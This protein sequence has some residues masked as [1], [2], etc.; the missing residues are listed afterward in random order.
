MT[1]V[2]CI[3]KVAYD[4][5]EGIVPTTVLDPDCILGQRPTNPIQ[6]PNGL[7]LIL[8]QSNQPVDST[9][10][11]GVHPSV[12]YVP[13]GWNGKKWWMAFTPYP[14][15][16]AHYETPHILCADDPRDPNGWKVPEGGSNPI[17]PYVAG[18]FH[19][20]PHL[21]L[22]PD[23]ILYCYYGDSATGTFVCRFST[24]GITWSEK[25][26]VINDPAAMSPAIMFD[27]GRYR[28]WYVHLIRE[29]D[30]QGPFADQLETVVVNG[31]TQKVIYDIA[32]VNDENSDNGILY[33]KIESGEGNTKN[34]LFYKD[35]DG[36]TP[37]ASA[38]CTG[39][40]KAQISQV[41]YSGISGSIQLKA[42][43]QL[44]SDLA[45]NTI[46]LRRLC[47]AES[48]HP[49]SDFSPVSRHILP[50]FADGP[51]LWHLSVDKNGSMFTGTF[52][53]TGGYGHNLHI[54]TS[55]DGTTWK[56]PEFPFLASAKSGTCGSDLTG[57]YGEGLK[58]RYLYRGQ[59][60]WTTPDTGL[61]F[62]SARD[63]FEQNLYHTWRIFVADIWIN[64]LIVDA[65]GSTPVVAALWNKGNVADVNGTGVAVDFNVGAFL[66]YYTARLTYKT[67]DA[68]YNLQ[69]PIFTLDLQKKGTAY[70]NNVT[71]VT[72]S[73]DGTGALYMTPIKTIIG[74]GT[75]S[76]VSGQYEWTMPQ[77]GAG[78]K[79]VLVWLE[80]LVNTSTETISFPEHFLK[81]PHVY[82]SSSLVSGVNVATNGL[83]IPV[84][85]SP[86]TGWLIVEGY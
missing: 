11:Q 47:Y 48:N 8:D 60:V 83:T 73:F 45:A 22:G 21:M 20:D 77:K 79:K 10:S 58:D 63:E 28:L 82:G 42:N 25:Q 50:K 35:K 26:T 3:S 78:W 56:T 86:S 12:V 33:A 6:T 69:N 38:N 7:N 14:N 1:Q 74:A 17:E 64:R 72:L 32:G 27:G 67:T 44:T 23:N 84:N 31:V 9:G 34:V 80:N 4:R 13:Q 53:T 71:L 57:S 51:I 2:P 15:G 65:P 76:V 36:D 55:Q 54:C 5:I 46:D 43:A 59:I 66:E 37:V 41:N 39:N 75:G 24:D 40:I 61:L 16:D 19:A 62:Y 52:L 30:F 18:Y 70:R 29:S 68:P 85:Q 49:L 81:V